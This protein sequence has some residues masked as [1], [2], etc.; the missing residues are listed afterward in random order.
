MKINLNLPAIAFILLALAGCEKTSNPQYAKIEKK[1]RNKYDKAA[2]YT[3]SQYTELLN[4]LKE[5]KFIVLPINE[6]RYTF[7]KS[8]VVVGLRHDIDFNPFKA[9]EMAKIEKEKG[10]RSTYYILA[11][12]E[13]YG[14]FGIFGL[15]R[16]KGISNKT[17]N[18]KMSIVFTCGQNVIS[19]P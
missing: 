5:N 6:M 13:Y 11:T 16:N 14:H 3:W 2:T 10:L 15:V 8:K 4:K 9:I 12:S 1:I 18:T 19:G 17:E 7:I